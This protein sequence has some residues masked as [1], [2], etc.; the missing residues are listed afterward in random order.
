M[1]RVLLASYLFLILVAAFAME[2]AWPVSLDPRVHTSPQTVSMKISALEKS[3]MLAAVGQTAMIF[4]PLLALQNITNFSKKIFRRFS[5][6]IVYTN[7]KRFQR[8]K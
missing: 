4:A 3:V 6:L 1:K 2:P 5:D 7:E 8:T